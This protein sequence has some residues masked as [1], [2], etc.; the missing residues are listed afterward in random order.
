[1]MRKELIQQIAQKYT[2]KR[3]KTPMQPDGISD[4]EF[5][6][7]LVD[8][9]EA[10]IDSPSPGEGEAVAFAEWVDDKNYWRTEQGAWMTNRAGD[11]KEYTTAELYQLFPGKVSKEAE[12]ELLIRALESGKTLEKDFALCYPDQYHYTEKG[13]CVETLWMEKNNDKKYFY[14]QGWGSALGN[15]N[16]RVI[17]LITHPQYWSIK[18]TL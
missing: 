6:H 7:G 9:I 10:L 12:S 11:D 4:H 18:Q 17:E 8:D 1:M 2:G 3:Y 15:V 13:D 16:E 14:M 5:F